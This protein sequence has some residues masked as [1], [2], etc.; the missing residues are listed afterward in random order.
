MDQTIRLGSIHRVGKTGE[1]NQRW[2]SAAAFILNSLVDCFSPAAPRHNP[3]SFLLTAWSSWKHNLCAS[4]EN[5][6][7]SYTT[8]LPRNRTDKSQPNLAVEKTGR[9]CTHVSI[10]DHLPSVLL[11][12][13]FSYFLVLGQQGHLEIT[14]RGV[15]ASGKTAVFCRRGST[16]WLQNWNNKTNGIWKKSTPGYNQW[17]SWLAPKLWREAPPWQTKL[18]LGRSLHVPC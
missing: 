9:C 14:G 6:K 12:L 5:N 7:N 16:M 17:D 13:P 3:C 4:V 1:V 2:V 10:P 18:R 11:A 15:Q 8:F